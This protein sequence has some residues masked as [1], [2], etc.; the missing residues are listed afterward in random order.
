MHLQES[1]P[2][3]KIGC[4]TILALLLCVLTLAGMFTDSSGQVAPT[5]TPRP[6]GPPVTP[7]YGLFLPHIERFQN[8]II[9]P[10]SLYRSGKC[11]RITSL[12]SDTEL[13]STVSFAAARI[14]STSSSPRLRNHDAPM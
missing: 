10:T 3:D 4:M 2:I 8:G 11:A 14:M 9:S 7:T 12:H 6:T 1:L 13:V 5:W